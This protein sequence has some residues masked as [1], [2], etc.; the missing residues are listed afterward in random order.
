MSRGRALWIAAILVLPGLLA[1]F[2]RRPPVKPAG[3]TVVFLHGMGRSRV[4]MLI[5]K[6]R[7]RKAGYAVENFPYRQATE[8]LDDISKRLTGFIRERV[9]TPRYHLIGHSLGNIIIRHAFTKGYPDG[10]GRIVMLAPPNRPSR[11]AGKLKR[12]FLFRWVAGDSGQKLSDE[13][14]YQS[15][16]IPGV[17]FGVLAGDKGR[18]I[19][20]QAPNDGIVAVEATRLSG[21][22]DF[23]VV[24]RTHSFIMNS[25]EV[26]RLSRRFLET[27]SFGPPGGR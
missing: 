16:P 9:R 2:S 20:F 25:Q 5:L 18:N 27:G 14:F 12:N 10:L 13:E 19:G 3:D 1:G 15:L 6:K 8:S 24:H 4:S 23:A 17:E 26:F 22:K 21:M 7:F 11:Y